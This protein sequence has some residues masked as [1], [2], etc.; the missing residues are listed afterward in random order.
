MAKTW[1]L[2]TETKGTGAHIAPLDG[3]RRRAR[4]PELDLVTFE[5]P[6][7]APSQP[8]PRE[9]L[10]LKVVDVLGARVLGEDLGVRDAVRL[11][12]GMRSALDARIYVRAP[13]SGRWRLLSLDE[14]KALWRFR[15][16]TDTAA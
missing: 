11:L 3:D 1:V 14:V 5:R 12:E 15:R 9:P 2:D 16:E 13:D 10:K 4:E 6:A 8:A 7:R